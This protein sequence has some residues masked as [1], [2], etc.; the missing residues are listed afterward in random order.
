MGWADFLA[1]RSARRWLYGVAGRLEPGWLA[2]AAEP[3]LWPVFERHLSAVADAVRCEA[4][5]VPRQEPVTDLVLV[6]GHA[7]DVWRAAQAE[8]WTPPT[9]ALGWTAQEWTGLRLLA[10]YRL[11][12][13]EPRGPRLSRTAAELRPISAGVPRRVR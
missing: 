9:T 2:L 12:S 6:A 5:L 7:H 11:A 8:G 3:Q 10:C 4:D 13:A 1:D